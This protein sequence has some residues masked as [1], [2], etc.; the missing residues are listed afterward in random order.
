MNILLTNDDGI[1]FIFFTR[2]AEALRELSGHTLF[3]IAPDGE[4]SGFSHHITF[5]SGPV[6]LKKQA[7]N[8]WAC[9][10]TP[11]DCVMMGAMDALGCSI[12]FVVSGINNGANLGTDIIYSGTA[13]AARQAVLHG[14]PSAAFSLVRDGEKT[15]FWDAAIA[16]S[17]Q[18]LEEFV[19][20]WNPDVFLNVNLPNTPQGP[21]GYELTFP[22]RRYYPDKIKLFDA[23][24][25]KR[26]CFMDAGTSSAESEPG[27][28]YDAVSRNKASISAVFIHPVVQRGLCP[29][30]PGHAAVESRPEQRMNR[31]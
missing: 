2:F 5:L 20:L 23:P 17:V 28:D 3:V 26:Y 18:H 11:A 4:R 13:A 16:Y 27:S 14:I 29:D 9:S 15:A 6:R 7:E 8:V 25:R 30:A 12:D 24:D 19:G 21:D 22:V 31:K 10:G 1:D